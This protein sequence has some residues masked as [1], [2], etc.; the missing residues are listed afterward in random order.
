M[1]MDESITADDRVTFQAG[2]HSDAVTMSLA[3]FRRVAQPEMA[4]FGRHL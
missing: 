2:T 1:L 4:Y 3:E